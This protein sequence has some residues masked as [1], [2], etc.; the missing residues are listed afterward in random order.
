MSAITAVTVQNTFGVSGVYPLPAAAV[1]EQ[2]EAVGTDLGADA[3]KTGML[4]SA[5]I[6][7]AVADKIE[8]FGWQRVVVDPVMIAKGGAELL[9]DDAVDA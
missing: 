7:E 5:D 4:F 2:I 3:V 9:Q 1:A 6:I 8:A